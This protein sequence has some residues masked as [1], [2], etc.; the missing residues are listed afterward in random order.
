MGSADDS[1]VP[2]RTDALLLQQQQHQQQQQLA[3]GNWG[4]SQA[5][6]QHMGGWGTGVMPM[7]LPPGV[8]PAAGPGMVAAIASAH[9]V[10]AVQQQQQQQQMLMPG[11]AN[12]GRPGDAM[13]LAAATSR[14]AAVQTLQLVQ[15][16]L[17]TGVQLQLQQQQ[18]GQVGLTQVTAG[19]AAPATLDPQQ[20]LDGYQSM[21]WQ[22]RGGCRR[23]LLYQCCLERFMNDVQTCILFSFGVW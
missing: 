21:S 10:T 12:A 5:S 6:G 4:A 23:R 19:A 15:Q 1:F 20:L 3:V 13:W 8:Q 14:P 2:L 17:P 9:A 16:G 11:A 7:S 22:V 18:R